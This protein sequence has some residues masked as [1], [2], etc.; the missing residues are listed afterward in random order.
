MRFRATTTIATGIIALFAIALVL[1]RGV[2]SDAHQNQT[3]SYFS[4]D[5]A[6]YLELYTT[7]YHDLDLEDNLA[8]FMIGSPILFMKFANGELAI[9]QAMNLALMA[10]SLAVGMNCFKSGLGRRLFLAGSL[11]FPYFLFGFISLNKEIYGMASAIFLSSY[12]LRGKRC[13]LA[14]ALLL[15]AC[16]R[17]YMLAA[18]VMVLVTI[19]RKGAPQF[20]LMILVLLGLTILAPLT[21]E[22]IPGYSSDN[23]LEDSGGAGQV[24][25]WVIDHYGYAIAYP[26]K[27]L[28]LIPM[29]AYGFLQGSERSADGMEA[30]VSILTLCLLALAAKAWC[31]RRQINS[32]VKR[33]IL[34]ACVAPVPIMWTEI[35]HWRYYSFVYFL[36]LPAVILHFA[37]GA[38]EAA[39]ERLRDGHAS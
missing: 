33:L 31:Q 20:L 10:W 37:E 32:H 39:S 6:N 16:S 11:L 29:R 25:A 35:M 1:T 9:V 19:P 24:F 38:H 36:F 8:L 2:V 28:A 7:F 14:V 12:M 23:L 4:S 3:I 5:G 30:V 21:K 26:A 13:H 27:Y 34:A 18:V 15:A 17:Y 22:V